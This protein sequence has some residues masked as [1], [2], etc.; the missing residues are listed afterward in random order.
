MI[1]QGTIN[2][3][4]LRAVAGGLDADQVIGMMMI[5]FNLFYD[6][7]KEMYNKS[8]KSMRRVV[9]ENGKARH[10]KIPQAT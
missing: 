7:A 1:G 6:T 5:N 8:V 10:V 9:L 3:F 4:T 2:A